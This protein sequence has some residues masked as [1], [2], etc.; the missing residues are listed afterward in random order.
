MI[1]KWNI[2]KKEFAKEIITLYLSGAKEMKNKSLEIFNPK[3][4]ER[5]FID[6]YV[7]EEKKQSVSLVG[8]FLE[9]LFSNV[10]ETNGSII[11]VYEKV[12]SVYPIINDEKDNPLWDKLK[13]YEIEKDIYKIRSVDTKDLIKDLEEV[14]T[15]QKKAFS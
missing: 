13:E 3:N 12:C 5:V 14:S 11:E 6:L 15:K 9:T 4:E 10:L 2:L 8:S 1:Y 7:P